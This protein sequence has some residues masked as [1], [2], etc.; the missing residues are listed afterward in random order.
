[1]SKKSLPVVCA[2]T[3]VLAL[4]PQR[5]GAQPLDQLGNRASALGAFV[6]VADDASAVV[7]NPAGLINGPI[8][9]ILLDFGR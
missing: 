9:N 1:M 2:L 7:W 5:S 3:C 4:A 6:A 8:F